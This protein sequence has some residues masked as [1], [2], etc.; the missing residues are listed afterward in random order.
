MAVELFAVIRNDADRFLPAVLQ[1]VQT[2]CG[3]GCGINVPVGA[4]QSTFFMRMVV[5]Q[6][7]NGSVSHSGILVL[8]SLNW[9]WDWSLYLHRYR[10]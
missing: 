4:V 9:N 6:K 5:I 7:I 1:C 10:Q 2:K 3:M 8:L